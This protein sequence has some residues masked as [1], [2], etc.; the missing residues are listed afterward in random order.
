[1]SDN[2][3]DFLDELGIST[4]M[5][6]CPNESSSRSAMAESRRTILSNVGSISKLSSRTCFR[7]IRVFARPC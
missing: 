5:G 6:S 3:E 1:M 7:L 2:I 4:P